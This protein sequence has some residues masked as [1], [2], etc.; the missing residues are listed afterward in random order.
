MGLL[1]NLGL[2]KDKAINAQFNP[3]VMGDNYGTNF[4]GYFGTSYAS[5]ILRNEAMQVPAMMRA[6]N[7]ICGVIAAIPL[8]L[9]DKKTGSKL[10]VVP[11]WVDQPDYRQPRSTTIAWTVDSLLFH[12]CAYWEVVTEYADGRPS[13]MAWVSNDRVSA[14]LRN[15]DTVVDY[16]L[17]DGNKRPFSG[18]G[19]IITF[20]SINGDGILATAAGTLRAA[21]D[22]QNA[23]SI[24]AASPMATGYIQN[25]GA[26]I[27]EASVESLLNRWRAKRKSN[28][29]AYLT[30][31]L[32]YKTV[33]F[34]PKDM[35]YVDSI[36]FMATQIA[37]ACNLSAYWL[38]ADITTSNTY[39]NRIDVRKDLVDLT[40][41]SFISSI[42][43]RLSMDDICPRG[44]MVRFAVDETFLR[45]DPITRLTVIEKMLQLQ[46]IDLPEAKEMEGLADEGS[47]SLSV[48][49]NTPNA[50]VLD[51]PTMPNAMGDA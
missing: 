17:V 22:I 34:S 9:I 44:Q 23:A 42:E 48:V 18:A 25:H 12:P 11:P 40:L 41:R 1:R 2:T 21:L 31:T 4:N 35:A 37:R 46:L 39:Q 20:Q 27:P 45:N 43:D 24:A 3:P 32:E 16:Y 19:S 33:G 29:T 5:P 50:K 51:M 13:D 47:D 49:P 10:D 14:V 8:E 30:S 6:R 38:D 36:Q 7:L 26:D 15:Y 28:A